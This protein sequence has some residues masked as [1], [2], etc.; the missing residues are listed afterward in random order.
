LIEFAPPRQ[1]HRWALTSGI[2]EMKTV[3]LLVTLGATLLTSTR[4]K[5]Q[6]GIAMRFRDQS[7]RVCV[8]GNVGKPRELQFDDRLSLAVAINQ[9]GGIRPHSR[10]I[11]IYVTKPIGGRPREMQ[12]IKFGVGI[13]KKK[14]V[15][16]FE[17]HDRDVIEV[18]SQKRGEAPNFPYNLCPWVPFT[19]GRM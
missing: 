11:R 13:F 18:S 12:E 2:S 4:S 9:A 3:F 5:Q 10:D 1:L 14:S 15:M 17:L 6:P 8:V 19:Q 7:K 16:A